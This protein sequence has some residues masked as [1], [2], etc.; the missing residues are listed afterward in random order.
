MKANRI[1]WTDPSPRNERTPD[2]KSL[3][4]QYGSEFVWLRRDGVVHVIVERAIREGRAK[5][6]R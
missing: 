3:A 1:G 2:V 4:R 5:R 6:V